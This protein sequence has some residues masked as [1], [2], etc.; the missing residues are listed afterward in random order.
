MHSGILGKARH[1]FLNKKK[2]KKN[3]DKNKEGI[4]S[5]I[6]EL[7]TF[8]SE[9]NNK[10][11]LKKI[12]RLTKK[13]QKKI[14]PKKYAIYIKIG[15]YN[16]A[17]TGQILGGLS[18][19]YVIFGHNIIIEGDFDKARYE[20]NVKAVG[21]IRIGTIIVIGIQLLLDKNIRKI[22]KEKLVRN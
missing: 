9:K 21:K 17:T 22:V 12:W 13:L 11:A 1:K 4:F 14:K 3:T 2:L 15:M 6:S 8:F 20:G 18:F 5:R 16:P 10:K 19:L 7:K